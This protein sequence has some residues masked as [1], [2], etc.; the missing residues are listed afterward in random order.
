VD[1]TGFD[2]EE[3]DVCDTHKGLPCKTDAYWLFAFA[4]RS[5]SMKV[6]RFSSVDSG[7]TATPTHRKVSRSVSHRLC[8][9]CI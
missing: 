8:R 4:K 7:Q 5:N 2:T 9:F 3:E 1:E 6:Q